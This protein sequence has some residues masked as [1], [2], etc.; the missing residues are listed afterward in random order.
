M[1]I[2]PD[3]VTR[4]GVRRGERS[5]TKDAVFRLMKEMNER[6]YALNDEISHYFANVKIGAV[7]CGFYTRYYTVPYIMLFLDEKYRN[8]FVSMPVRRSAQREK[9]ESILTDDAKRE[10]YFRRIVTV[11]GSSCEAHGIDQLVKTAVSYTAENM[12]ND[13]ERIIFYLEIP[14]KKVKKPEFPGNATVVDL[15]P[16]YV[17]VK[18]N[19]LDKQEGK[20]I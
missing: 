11:I 17:D 5:C 4:R 16:T 6:E 13:G 14:G 12:V 1:S 8:N 10:R 18:E 9:L 2:Q 15:T 20:H 3:E 7:N 19:K